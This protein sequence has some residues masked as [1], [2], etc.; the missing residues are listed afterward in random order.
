MAGG[1]KFME[2]EKFET[3]TPA[4][5]ETPVVEIKTN[6]EKLTTNDVAAK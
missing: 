5:P 6:P 1:Y 3:V 2:E 4:S